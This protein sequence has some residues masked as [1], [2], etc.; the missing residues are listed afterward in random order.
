MTF[1]EYLGHP[2]EEWLPE[3]AISV[4]DGLAPGAQ[5]CT[6]DGRSMGN[7]VIM[8][9]EKLTEQGRKYWPVLTD[10]GTLM[11]LST[12]EIK[13][14]FWPPRWVMDP[15]RAPGTRV[16]LDQEKKGANFLDEALNSGDGT[17]RP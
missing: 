14:A 8:G 3:W 16:Y 7:A 13:A 11:R 15:R 9:P 1:D 17:Y 5:L 10:A 6:R 2:E 4:A 12:E